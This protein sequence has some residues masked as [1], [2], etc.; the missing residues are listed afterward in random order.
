MKENELKKLCGEKV[1]SDFPEFIDIEP[2]IETIDTDVKKYSK[3][4][5]RQ[6]TGG[7]KKIYGY[8]YEKH[9]NNFKKILRIVID[10]NG[11]IIKI[12]HS[13]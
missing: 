9:V 10:E 12:T 8:V 7:E 4:L 1:R 11:N 13:K 5:G 2:T 6:F 3:Q